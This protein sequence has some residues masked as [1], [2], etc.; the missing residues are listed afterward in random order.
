MT[1]R[2]DQRPN[3]AAYRPP[4]GLTLDQR[5]AEQDAAAGG[6]PTR[7]VTRDD[8]AIVSASVAL[9]CYPKSRRVYAYLRWS[10]SSGGTAERYIGDVSDCPDRATALR[11]AW[12]QAV[13]ARRAPVPQS[14]DTPAR[15]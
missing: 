15:T 5:A 4:A 2:R 8:G 7:L 14:T 13:L 9:R 3:P 12:R 10:A 6:R 11:V 1:R